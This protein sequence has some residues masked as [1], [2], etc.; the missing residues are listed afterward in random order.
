MADARCPSTIINVTSAVVDVDA[1]KH[2]LATVE[3]VSDVALGLEANDVGCAHILV[4][5][6]AHGCGKNTP[7]AWA[8][9]WYVREMENSRRGDRLAYHRRR[10]IEVVVLQQNIRRL[11]LLFCFINDGFGDG[12]VHGYI[13]AFPGLIH[14]AANV[15]CPRRIPHKGL[16]EPEEGIAEDVVMS[17]IDG[18]RHGDETNLDFVV[19]NPQQGT[20][21]PL[22]RLPVSIGHRGG[23]PDGRHEPCRGQERRDHSASSALRAQ[24]AVA[25]DVV[26]NRAA[27]TGDDEAAAGEHLSR[28]R[29]ESLEFGV[30]V[31]V[32]RCHEWPGSAS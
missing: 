19:R 12:L 2:R 11:R 20:F 16:D 5:S 9:P 15:R 13:A 7:V 10:E 21:R 31:P 29:L 27:V 6:T 4:D 17:L 22:S 24:R 32:G 25:F 14:R 26:F 8:G 3:E 1:F 23:D 18:R 30:Y 28:Q